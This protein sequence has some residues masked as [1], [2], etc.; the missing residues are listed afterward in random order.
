M[1]H[2]WILAPTRNDARRAL[3][4]WMV[5]FYLAYGRQ[6]P[7]SV[8]LG[9]RSADGTLAA[10]V[11]VTPYLE[12]LPE[13]RSMTSIGWLRGP[14]GGKLVTA[15]R[16]AFA[17]ALAGFG[18]LSDKAVKQRFQAAR[19]VGREA[20]CNAC[21]AARP[22]LHVASLAVKPAVRGCQHA[23]TLLRHINACADELRCACY[24]ECSGE[25][26]KAM[27][28][29]FGYSPLGDSP[30]KVGAAL[31]AGNENAAGF[32]DLWAM[33]R[34]IQ[35]QALKDG[36]YCWDFGEHNSFQRN[37]PSYMKS[38]ADIGRTPCTREAM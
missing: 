11:S 13:M 3:L 15:S 24:L 23:S 4:R 33:E 14:I 16:S 9:V 1:L 25:R 37:K 27:F 32:A 21:P 22:H 20:H 7:G 26:A 28:A 6:C 30:L 12:G 18:G 36:E 29:R 10:V 34:K 19:A 38:P 31:T 17:F 8:L 5:R 35:R 2:A